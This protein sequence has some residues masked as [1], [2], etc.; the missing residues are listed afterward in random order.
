MEKK[1]FLETVT[2]IRRLLHQ[3]PETE[4]E[5]IKTAQIISDVLNKWN[6]PHQKGIAKTGITADIGTGSPLLLLRADMD[7]LPVTE[8]TGLPFSSKHPGKMHACG[9]DIHMSCLL[10]CLLLF[11]EKPPENGSIRFLFQP[12]E[13]GAGGAEPMIRAGAAEGISAAA[14]L[15]VKPGL[16]TGK[17]ACKPGEYYASPDEFSITVTGRGGHGGY[18]HLANNPLPAAAK[19]I[20]EIQRLGQTAEKN[21][22]VVSICAV[23][24]GNS[25]NVIPDSVTIFGTARTLTEKMRNFLDGE[26]RTLSETVCASEKVTCQYHFRRLYP[27]VYNNPEL[28]DLLFR[29][30]AEVLGEEN[31][32]HETEPFMGGEDFAYFAKK[33]P[34]VL[35]HLGSGGNA[36][37]HSAEFVADEACI[38]YGSKI[39]ECF[40]RNYLKGENQHDTEEKIE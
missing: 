3:Y 15:H 29:T 32:L 7:A 18:P 21:N 40:A 22:A 10:G 19:I 24:G 26:I 36:H 11:R 39:L 17:I 16:E 1:L 25:F 13:E 37:L 23:N 28:T 2:P 6:I 34:G 8:H 35:F 20:T 31:V 33:A 5:E 14:A 27:P 9:H 30:G 38:W 4:F 12:A